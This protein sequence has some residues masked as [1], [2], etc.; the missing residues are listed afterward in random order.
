MD[1][2]KTKFLDRWS[3]SG[4]DAPSFCP[5][6]AFLHRCFST[7]AVKGKVEND[8]RL[9]AENCFTEGG[10]SAIIYCVCMKK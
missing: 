2:A 7:A 6:T 5:R 3:G 4:K 8:L 1:E 9:F 10:K